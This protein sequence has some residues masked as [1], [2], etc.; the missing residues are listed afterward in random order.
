MCVVLKEMGNM[1]DSQGSDHIGGTWGQ[2][3]S[4]SDRKTMATEKGVLVL[5]EWG[6]I[7]TF[8]C[9]K[10]KKLSGC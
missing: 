7:A 5:E 10:I 2:R 6:K 8:C 4:K 3:H 9:K 1:W